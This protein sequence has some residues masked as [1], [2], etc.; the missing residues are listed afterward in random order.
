MDKAL[1]QRLI[2]AT[3]L[4]LLAVI[5]LPMLLDGSDPEQNRVISIETPDRPQFDFESRRLPLDE[6]V[7][8]PASEPVTE[9]VEQQGESG[10]GTT[11]ASG[12]DARVPGDPGDPVVDS[13]P[14]QAATVRPLA[15]RTD[16]G[17]S[18]GPDAI[19]TAP[20]A[21]D[22][23]P[24]AAVTESADEPAQAAEPG[25]SGGAATVIQVA[26]FS[27]V[28]NAQRL[29]SQLTTLG[30]DSSLD[31][32]R[33]GSGELT[34]VRVVGVSDSEAAAVIQRIRNSVSGVNPTV[35]SLASGA[36]AAEPV[37]GRWAV[38]VGSFS[39]AANADNLI[40]QLKSASFRAF[41]E[42]SN[43]GGRNLI[44]VK[45]GPVLEREDA[46]AL[47]SRV[48]AE[49]GVEGVVVSYP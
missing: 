13:R 42:R 26:S 45:V 5:F 33:T 44:K 25:S 20:E 47:L 12:A 9:P 38:Q 35:V 34:R 15:D 3:I 7:A 2:G 27:D 48:R 39:D 41:S 1:K 11:Q 29:A 28:D 46:E 43:A 6:Q 18:P 16:S 36:A 4:I 30:L 31:T 8:S 24:A 32:V 37:S 49:T 19:S 21:A 23:E 10:V 40:E 14:D 17:Q 22:S